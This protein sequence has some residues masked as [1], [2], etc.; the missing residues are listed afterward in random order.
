MNSEVLS[1][2]SQNIVRVLVHGSKRIPR[3]LPIYLQDAQLNTMTSRWKR[4]PFFLPSFDHNF[5]FLSSST[6]GWSSKAIHHRLSIS[7]LVTSFP[8]RNIFLPSLSFVSLLHPTSLTGSIAMPGQPPQK[9]IQQ[10]PPR[11]THCFFH[12]KLLLWRC[13]ALIADEKAVSISVSTS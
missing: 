10:S 11:R 3:A 12:Y 6:P 13:E 4:A 7:T 2:L 5:F 9:A 8:P 1:Q